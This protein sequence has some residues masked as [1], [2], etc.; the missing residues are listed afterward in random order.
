MDL[1]EGL[2]ESNE[3]DSILVIVER[4]TKMAL[5]IPT[6]RRLTAPELARLYVLHVFSKHGVPSDVISDRGSEFVSSFWMSLSKV[7]DMDLRPS[8]AYHPQTDG[9]TERTN[10]TLET[11]LR[12]YINYQQDDWVD[13]LPIAEFA[14]NNSIHSATTLSPFF[15]N[16][17]YHPRLTMSLDKDVPSAEA[18][19]FSKSI[20]ELHDFV[21]QELTAAQA[22]YQT[23]ADERRNLNAPEFNEGDKVWLLSRN[24]KTQRPMKKLDHRRLGPYTISKKISSHA[25][26]LDLP[27][28]LSAIHNV[29]HIDLLEPYHPNSIP[30]RSEPPPPPVE[31]AGNEEF[32][33]DVILDSRIFRRQFQYLVKWKGYEASGESNSWEPASHLQHSKG[34]ISDFH[35]A[36]PNKPRPPT[37]HR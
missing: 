11:Y 33:V 27:R 1:I 2:P 21:R 5:F 28:N 9:Q 35:K 20:S 17:G 7:L 15:A 34:V 36:H 31:I 22:Q 37:K 14:Y 30:G 23:P 16:Y 12:T 18:H 24:I 8:T 4:L 3:Q 25:F 19:D 10:Q 32:E 29:F 13:Y 26:R 6:T